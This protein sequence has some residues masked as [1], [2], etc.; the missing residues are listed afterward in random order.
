MG[1]SR[2]LFVYF[3][4]FFVTISIQIVKS[5]DVVLRIQTQGHRMA[6]T[7]PRGYSIVELCYDE[8]DDSE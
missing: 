8:I 6:Q 4:P 1:Q 5:V 3:C 7:K 2:P